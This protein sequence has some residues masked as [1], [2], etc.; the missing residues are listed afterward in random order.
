MSVCVCVCSF[1][2]SSRSLYF[3]Q[4][5]SC[6]CVI[7][8]RATTLSVTKAL[9]NTYIFSLTWARMHACTGTHTYEIALVLTHRI[10]EIY[11]KLGIFSAQP[12]KERNMTMFNLSSMKNPSAHYVDDIRVWRSNALSHSP[13]FAIA[14]CCLCLCMSLQVRYELFELLALCQL[15]TTHN[16]SIEFIEVEIV[17][18]P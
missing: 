12:K 3:V 13:S 15:W 9:A 6:V 17:Q 2:I 11:R 10:S 4:F 16:F 7:H 5:V 1:L 8:V 14:F 18:K